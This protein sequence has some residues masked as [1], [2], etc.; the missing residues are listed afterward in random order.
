MPGHLRASYQTNEPLT[1][2]SELV[3]K[4][5]PFALILTLA[6]MLTSCGSA[7]ITGGGPVV[8]LPSETPVEPRP[9][10]APDAK[11]GISLAFGAPEDMG[12][13][14]PSLFS[15]SLTEGL[16]Q[17]GFQPLLSFPRHSVDRQR[18]QV[19]EMIDQGVKVIIISAL[20][21]T[22]MNDLMAIA[23]QAG[24]IIIA[25][26]RQLVNTEDVDMYIGWSTCL[27]GQ[28]QATTLLEGLAAKK[29]SPP[30]N[31]ELIAGS[32]D[33][34]NAA[35]LFRCAMDVLGPKIE[36]GTLIVRSGQI[37]FKLVATTG[38]RSDYVRTRFNR[39]FPK[40]YPPG[41]ALDGILAPEDTLART[42]VDYVRSHSKSKPI[43]TGNDSSIESIQWIA[44]GRQYATIYRSDRALAAEVIRIVKQLQLGESIAFNDTTTYDNGVKI[45]PAFVLTP[46]SVTK[47]N[48]CSVF[49]T[50]SIYARAAA[51][52]SYCKN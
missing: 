50:K 12:T 3:K 5:L 9:T 32:E 45:V 19:E 27:T 10:F 48:L 40:N 51:K 8:V 20:D 15:T 29:G 11:I 49:D 35:I 42:A 22:A 30:W 14:K 18:S 13:K 28:L 46:A 2:Y 6:L 23:K 52:T 25:L 33:D 39:I 26:E 4:T 43:V 1:G 34:N 37:S 41:T 38:W 17:A 31:I 21:G 24:I 47:Q 36:D 7:T 16:T 44:K